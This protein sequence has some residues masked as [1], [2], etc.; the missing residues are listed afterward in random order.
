M[1][2]SQYSRWGNGRKSLREAFAVWDAMGWCDATLDHTKRW[3]LVSEWFLYIWEMWI[4]Q[5]R[6]LEQKEID[7]GVGDNIFSLSSSCFNLYKFFFFNL[8][9]LLRKGKMALR[10][11]LWHCF[12][13]RQI[14][15]PLFFFFFILSFFISTEKES[16]LIKV[17][18]IFPS[19]HQNLT[20]LTGNISP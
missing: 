14:R 17:F 9:Y 10:T 4:K 1:L 15:M 18:D 3:A 19:I 2:F 11:A 5:F 16:F 12:L 7:Q 13:F 20:V 8:F 6:S